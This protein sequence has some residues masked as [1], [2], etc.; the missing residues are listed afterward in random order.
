[1]A[2]SDFFGLMKYGNKLPLNSR[3]IGYLNIFEITKTRIRDID[4]R[5]TNFNSVR[6]CSRKTSKL[7]ASPRIV[8]ARVCGRIFEW[9]YRRNGGIFFI[10][11]TIFKGWAK[12]DTK[13]GAKRGRE[14]RG[15]RGRVNEIKEIGVISAWYPDRRD[16][17]VLI[18]PYSLATKMY[19][20]TTKFHACSD[21]VSLVA[22]SIRR[23]GNSNGTRSRN[24]ASN[25]KTKAS[26]EK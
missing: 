6:S 15:V 4:L 9:I 13:C 2:I 16:V 1:M 20:L 7:Q 25:G 26:V 24:R 12:R 8:H 22:P 18:R 11:G 19:P 14:V 3:C 10:R 17:L 23:L 5:P 21:F